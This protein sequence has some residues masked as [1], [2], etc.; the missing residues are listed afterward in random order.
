[1]SFFEE[2]KRRNVVRVGLAY[3]V[4][5]WVLAQ[6]A[7]FA[8]E[9]FGAPEW[10]LKSFVVALL[11][12]LPIALILAWAFEMTADGIKRE[13]DV[14]REQSITQQT[15]RKLNRLISV[16]LAVAVIV[17]VAERF[18]PDGADSKPTAVDVDQSIA[19][20]PFVDLSDNQKDEF[21]G[22]GVA[23]ELLNALAR[24]PELRVAARTSAFSF[25]G[26]D[27]DLRKIG[28]SLNVAHVL[29][30]SV[31][32]GTEMIRVTAQLI[33]SSDGMHL[34]SETY[35]QPESDVLAIQD[36][37]VADISRALEIRLGVGA[38]AGRA[39]QHNI[40]P[41]AYEAYLQ[42][43]YQWSTRH[44]DDN[45]A[46]SIRNFR[47]ATDFDPQFADA[48]AAYALSLL[49]TSDSPEITGLTPE[50]RTDAVSEA[51]RIAL[52]L[53]PDNARA[54]AAMGSFLI[55]WQLDL[56]KG[57]TAMDRAVAL[58]PN[59][60]LSHYS[61]A[62]NLILLGDYVQARRAMER[63]LV[64]DP[65]NVTVARVNAQLQIIQG[66]WAEAQAFFDDCSSKNCVPQD[67]L[68]LYQIFARA[69]M[70]QKEL[71]LAALERVDARLGGSAPRDTSEWLDVTRAFIQSGP[72]TL[73]DDM[74]DEFLSHSSNGR[75]DPISA[76][77]LAHNRPEAAVAYLSASSV[78]RFW[79]FQSGELLLS[80]GAF[81]F[82]DEFRKF[83]G[84][85]DFWARDGWRD[86]ARARIAN[87]QTAGLPL[88]DDGS[89]VE[90]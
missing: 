33:R 85:R 56:D 5:G 71:A 58:A 38:G 90:F 55:R 32:R 80:K 78:E 12:G 8:F 31:R 35:D 61:V 49:F 86:I 59:S 65:L 83:P 11:L 2:L 14:E 54:H 62:L 6:I 44:L 88:N 84:Y 81:E 67:E 77:T 19:V 87:G 51:L 21:F 15:G 24:F 60:A 63:T 74:V 48:H 36:D 34:W 42:G 9:N 28:D 40:V 13:R 52:E 4:I 3:A 43:L 69:H 10:V 16:V 30:G 17:L 73:P 64:L 29:E 79:N 76:L 89:L 1:M 72:M 45:R 25:A 23:E 70:G 18:L 37:I 27:I 50:D 39:R 20:L 46:G 66:R 68:D 57:R 75:L 22:R 41:R 53:D 26:E 47:L 82:P 7:E